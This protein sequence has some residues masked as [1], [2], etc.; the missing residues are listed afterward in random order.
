[1]WKLLIENLLMFLHLY[2]WCSNSERYKLIETKFIGNFQHGT[3]ESF[4]IISHV[5][6]KIIRCV[7]VRII[8][9]KI[10]NNL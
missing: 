5:N 9:L 1:M 3:K 8:I 4:G 7:I 10:Y 6:A 2:I